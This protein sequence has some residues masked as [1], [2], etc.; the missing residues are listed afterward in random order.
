MV[1]AFICLIFKF[2]LKVF[3]YNKITQNLKFYFMCKDVLHSR[4]CTCL[5]RPEEGVRAPGT[6]SQMVVCHPVGAAG[7]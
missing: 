6:E 7:N 5:W 2:A 1:A 3:Q 4:H